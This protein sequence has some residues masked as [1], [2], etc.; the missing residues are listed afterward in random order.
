MRNVRSTATQSKRCRAANLLQAISDLFD[1][2]TPSGLPTGIEKIERVTLE[3]VRLKFEDEI[4]EKLLGRIA[5]EEGYTTEKGSFALRV[6]KD[7]TIVARVGSRS[8]AGAGSDL[9]LYLFPPEMGE[10]SIYGRIVAQRE[11]VLDPSTGEKN[12]GNLYLFNLKVIKLVSRYIEQRY[13]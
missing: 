6:V 11:A 12:L 10:I 3:A 9:Y 2:R 13:A 5:E 1:G 7:G 4:D 8:D